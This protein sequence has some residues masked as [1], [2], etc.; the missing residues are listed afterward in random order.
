VF[1]REIIAVYCENNAV[2]HFVAIIAVF[3][4]GRGE[5]KYVLGNIEVTVVTGIR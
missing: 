1:F 4:S 2:I 3:L 5:Y